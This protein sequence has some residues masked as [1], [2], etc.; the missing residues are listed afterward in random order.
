[1]ENRIAQIN[2]IFEELNSQTDKFKQ[3]HV[4]IITLNRRQDARATRS[5]T[6]NI[7]SMNM[8]PQIRFRIKR[9]EFLKINK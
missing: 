2:Q 6:S 3:K 4:N 5:R 9:G 1:M 8:A 7:T